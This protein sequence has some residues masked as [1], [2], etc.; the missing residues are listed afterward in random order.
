MPQRLHTYGIITK[1]FKVIFSCFGFFFP[2]LITLRIYF[3]SPER[4][5]EIIST[6]QV[7]LRFL[8]FLVSYWIFLLPT[9]LIAAYFFS[10]IIVDADGLIVEFLWM[11]LKVQWYEIVEVKPS[12]R[13]WLP[14]FG[15]KFPIVV[16]TN[17]LT[18]FHRLFGLLY[19][20]SPLPGF[21]INVNISEYDLLIKE[22]E[23]HIKKKIL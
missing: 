21:V 3:D 2:I 5:A 7:L 8:I 17:A 16:L 18:P 1:G 23:R 9:T 4:F 12:F 10:D 22:I 6:E 14:T 11:K 15:G 19:G 20:L 13:W